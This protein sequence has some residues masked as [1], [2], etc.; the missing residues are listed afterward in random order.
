MFLRTARFVL[1]LAL[2][3]TRGHAQSQTIHDLPVVVQLHKLAP[4]QWVERVWGDPA[5]AGEGFAIRIHN[6]AG[7]IVVPHVHP[8][9][10]HVVVVQGVWWFGMGS[11][12]SA[13]ALKPVEL[14]AFAL[15]PK[16]IPHFA[17][18]K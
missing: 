16:N 6:D 15:G 2:T 7:Y 13:S 18:S 12:F 9:D 11:R 5:K 3:V 17:W 14:G 1:Y 4:G 8:M 10:E